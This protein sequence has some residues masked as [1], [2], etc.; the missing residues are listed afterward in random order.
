M[1]LNGSALVIHGNG[2]SLHLHRDVQTQTGDFCVGAGT[3]GTTASE[4]FQEFL[5]VEREISAFPPPA[6]GMP[7]D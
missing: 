7:K 5:L 1:E 2:Y 3:V 6:F 4:A